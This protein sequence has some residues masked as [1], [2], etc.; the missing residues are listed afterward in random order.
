M[1]ISKHTNI[2]TIKKH[3]S[4]FVLSLL[5]L[6]ISCSKQ[7]LSTEELTKNLPEGYSLLKV[8]N[9]AIEFK[10][11]KLDSKKASAK[12]TN[13]NGNSK[14]IT[15][16][17]SKG[18]SC[19]VTLE[20]VSNNASGLN[21]ASQNKDKSGEIKN[22]VVD[23]GVRYRLYVYETKSGD[24]VTS[25]TYIRG[26]EENEDPLMI[27]GDLQYTIVAYSINSVK[28]YPAE[29]ENANN[30]ST[31]TITN[32]QV[33]FMFHKQDIYISQKSVS[34]INLKFKH[35][36][37]QINTIVKLDATTSGY[38]QIRGIN[39]ASYVRP[40]YSKTKFKVS[41]ESISA[42]EKDLQL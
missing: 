16:T 7:Q 40:S 15:E 24:L 37:A 31:A 39:G 41:D 12:L 27:V 32:A 26:E 3:H 20:P 19:D 2:M 36:F 21:L 8:N 13:T 42:D 14:N 10:E 1:E 35:Q 28:D 18:I 22:K 33:E 23:L 30:I 29:L 6:F 5:F 4:Y 25:A 9:V 34:T 11:E 17:S 38:T